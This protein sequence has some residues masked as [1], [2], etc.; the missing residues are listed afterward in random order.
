M[1]ICIYINVCI[2][3]YINIYKLKGQYLYL[4]SLYLLV[5][6]SKI[7]AAKLLGGNEEEEVKQDRISVLQCHE[8]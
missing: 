4:L 6:F 1:C 7:S 8:V 5:H 3:M 2:K